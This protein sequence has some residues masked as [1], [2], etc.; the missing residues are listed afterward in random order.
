MAI[1]QKALSVRL[2]KEL[3]YRL[4]SYCKEKGAMRNR[5]INHAIEHFLA[6]SN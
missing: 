6:A 1:T 4:D 5:V 3:L 2:N